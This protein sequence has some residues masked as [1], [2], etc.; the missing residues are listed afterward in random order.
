MQLPA[1]LVSM[2]W[3]RTVFCAQVLTTQ[4]E[5][6]EAVSFVFGRDLLPAA[7]GHICSG[8]V[9]LYLFAVTGDLFWLQLDVN[10]GGQGRRLAAADRN[11][12]SEVPLQRM[13]A[14][15]S[16]SLGVSR[17]GA[18]CV[19]FSLFGNKYTWCT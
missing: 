4:D 13:L 17:R 3:S 8:K 1:C 2:V 10:G 16:D 11:C 19:L 12:L 9:H 15:K 5:Q 18:N 14:F 6:P 7:C